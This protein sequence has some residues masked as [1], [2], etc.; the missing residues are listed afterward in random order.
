MVS[1]KISV[2]DLLR[3][4]IKDF[5]KGNLDNLIVTG[6]KS[7]TVKVENNTF[8]FSIRRMDNF[9]GGDYPDFPLFASI[10][11]DGE[12]TM[13]LEIIPIYFPNDLIGGEGLSYGA[14]EIPTYTVDGDWLV[15]NFNFSSN[16]Y[17]FN[18]KSRKEKMIKGVVENGINQF[19]PT[20][21]KSIPMRRYTTVFAN[22]IYDDQSRLIFRDHIVINESNPKKSE[23]Y[24]TV[25]NYN[26][27]KLS[28]LFI[29]ENEEIKYLRNSF[30][31]NSQ[32]FYNPFFPE[33]D[34]TLAFKV[35]SIVNN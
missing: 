20:F 22:I 32:I 19:K 13:Q 3:E 7:S 5:Y 17:M 11:I 4:K 29:G 15:Y 27:R 21:D 30:I 28:E 1:E 25:Y 18:L 9:S 35:F 6:S 14:E 31:Y 24:L 33:S 12:N 23:N 2:N 10:S 8:L 26:G 34:E 16:I